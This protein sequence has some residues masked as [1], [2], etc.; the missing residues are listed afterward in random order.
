MTRTR[1]C[2]V[3]VAVARKRPLEELPAVQKMIAKVESELGDEGRVLVRY[4]GTEAKARVMIEGPDEA[5][6]KAYADEIAETLKQAL[7]RIVG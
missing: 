4:S 7:T 5:G 1:R 2:C 3:N 6:I